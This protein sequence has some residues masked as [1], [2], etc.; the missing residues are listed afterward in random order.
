MNTV[1]KNFYVDDCLKSVI[2]SEH[3]VEFVD[4]L[5]ELLSKDGFRLTKWLCNK[6]EVTESI[7][8][9]ERAPSVLDL[10]LNK[11]R[12]PVQQTLGLK[13]DME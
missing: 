3:A 8:K 1:Q 2:S 11:E 10:D 13:W 5:R 9:D 12:L 6:P 7:P 4:Q